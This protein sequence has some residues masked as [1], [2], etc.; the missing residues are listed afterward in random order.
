MAAID[1]DV[2]LVDPKMRAF[3]TA[4]ES[5]SSAIDPRTFLDWMTAQGFALDAQVDDPTYGL[6]EIYRRSGP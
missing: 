5:G 2:I 1:P 6:M 3:L 4:P